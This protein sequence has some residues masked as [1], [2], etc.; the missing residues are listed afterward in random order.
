MG[1]TQKEIVHEHPQNGVD[2][3]DGSSGGMREHVTF[4]WVRGTG[5]VMEGGCHYTSSQLADDG[6]GMAE[7]SRAILPPHLEGTGED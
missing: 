6:R 1:Q 5:V 2:C 3:R 4:Q 7:I